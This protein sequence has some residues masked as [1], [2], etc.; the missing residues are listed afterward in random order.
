M[1]PGLNLSNV[2]LPYTSI[3]TP[4]LQKWQ[5]L[6]QWQQ[7]GERGTGWGVWLTRKTRCWSW[8]FLPYKFLWSGKLFLSLPVLSSAL[9]HLSLAISFVWESGKRSK[10]IVIW[11]IN[12]ML[13]FLCVVQSLQCKGSI[14]LL[15]PLQ[16]IWLVGQRNPWLPPHKLT[17][18]KDVYRV[19][20]PTL[21]HCA[22][23][24]KLLTLPTAEH[25]LL[26]A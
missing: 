10:P 20:A 23:F 22:K 1:A 8:I 17:E 4:G 6:W 7:F 26:C 16:T 18:R 12:Q 19:T 21:L 24:F 15:L 11:V 13:L 14:V 9:T 2:M 5:Y 3:L 25:T